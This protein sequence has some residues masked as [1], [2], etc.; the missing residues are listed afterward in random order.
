V[1]LIFDLDGTILDISLKYN[2]L[3]DEIRINYGLPPVNYW[4]KRQEISD[5][6][7]CIEALGISQL[8]LEEFRNEWA[9]KIEEQKM[10]DLDSVLKDVKEKISL[11]NNQNHEIILCTARR[12][13]K[14][15]ANQLHGLGLDTIF[16]QVLTSNSSSGKFKILQN[17]F[18]ENPRDSFTNTWFI[19]DTAEDILVGKKLGLKTCGVLT[20]LGSRE[21]LGGAGADLTLASVAN[22]DVAN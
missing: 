17:Y 4:R 10:L 20:G 14:N 19:S 1:D 2:F 16:G 15:L 5:F 21:S 12:N 11:F 18:S 3:Y 13:I 6:S 7:L 8:R 22:F 9:S